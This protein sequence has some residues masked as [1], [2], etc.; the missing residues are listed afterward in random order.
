[1]CDLRLDRIAEEFDGLVIGAGPSLSPLE[2]ATVDQQAVLGAHLQL[3]AEASRATGCAVV[4][5]GEVIHAAYP[6]QSINDERRVRKA[7]LINPWLR[8]SRQPW[9]LSSRIRNACLSY[10]VH[11]LGGSAR[12]YDAQPWNAEKGPLRWQVQLTG[13]K[14]ARGSTQHIAQQGDK[15]PKHATEY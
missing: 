9:N 5:K 3:M 1:M 13:L 8:S 14:P 15:Q 2:Q 11:R 10:F 4:E 6:F 7:A 12:P